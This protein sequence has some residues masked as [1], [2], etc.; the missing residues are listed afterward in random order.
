MTAG[1]QPDWYMGWVEGAIRIIPNWESH[2][3]STTWSWQIFLPGVGLM[4]IL[5]TGLALWP[6]IEQWITGD[7]DEHHL[8]DRPRNAPTRTALGVAGMTWYGLFWLGGGN[9]ILATTFGVSLNDV[10]Y[11]LRAAVFLGPVL[12]F[13]ITKR[14]CLSLQ[15]RDRDR[16]LHG[17]ESGIIERDPSGTY[18]EA[19]VPVDHDEAFSLTQHKEYDMLEEGEEDADGNVI[20]KRRARASRFMYGDDVAKPTA[21]EIEE[22]HEHGDHEVL[23]NEHDAPALPR[24]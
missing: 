20:S 21:E 11:F 24:H 17:S 15:R 3:G 7:K 10:T 22:A 12:A 13:L 2:I 8:L 6:F 19:H 9:D 23:D 5:F 1:S 16:V 14:I 4:G 18:S